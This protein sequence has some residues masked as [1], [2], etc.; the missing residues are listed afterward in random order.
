M[1]PLYFSNENCEQDCNITALRCDRATSKTTF[2]R[3][4]Q[5]L[6]SYDI[7]VCSSFFIHDTLLRVKASIVVNKLSELENKARKIM[8]C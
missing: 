1:M 5:L 7:F 8:L 4:F 3:L 2:L 6:K